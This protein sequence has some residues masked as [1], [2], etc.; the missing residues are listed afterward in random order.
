MG[1]AYLWAVVVEAHSMLELASGSVLV[2][3]ALGCVCEPVAGVC[4]CVL[5]SVSVC[6]YASIALCMR[7]QGFSVHCMMRV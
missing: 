7:R 4:V 3:L 1:M 5:G 6:A 2:V